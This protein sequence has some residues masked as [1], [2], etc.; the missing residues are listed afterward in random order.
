MTNAK[1]PADG[2]KKQAQPPRRLGR[3]LSSLLGD[4]VA[5]T[6]PD[7]SEASQDRTPSASEPT[8]RDIQF[9][10]VEWINPGPWQPRR[11][12]DPAGLDELAGSIR[13]RGIIQP[14]LLRPNPENP[15][16]YQL[17]AGERRWRAAQKAQLHDIPALITSYD[18]KTSAEL[19]L[20]ENIQRRDLS[21]VEEAEGYKT[22]IDSHDY[23]H[24]E[25]AEIVGKSRP[26]IANLLRL[27]S[28]PASVQKMIIE[29][30]LSMGQARPLI[31]HEQAE[32]L[33]A[34]IVAKKLS[35]RQVEALIARLRSGKPGHQKPE[36]SSDIRAIEKNAKD[37]Y[38]LSVSLDW[39]EEKEKGKLVISL[40]SLDQ[41]DDLLARLGIAPE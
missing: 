37:K 29:Q 23:T 32:T 38:G 11:I 12:F 40:T 5:L 34:E 39:A 9:I 10:P 20:I 24:E 27:L 15:A 14:V 7:M 31:G 28:L 21:A 4:G 18:D 17:I 22:L 3:G 19:S 26:H 30:T 35:V 13:E 16:R 2:Q 36:K 1:P 8:G 33:A 41:L 6:P 25:L